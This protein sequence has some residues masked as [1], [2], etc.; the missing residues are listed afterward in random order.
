MKCSS[1]N[2]PAPSSLPAVGVVLAPTPVIGQ[3]DTSAHDYWR[4]G[5]DG[6]RD[7]TGRVW[8]GHEVTVRGY[9]NSLA[10]VAAV[11]GLAVE[12]LRPEELDVCDPRFPVMAGIACRKRAQAPSSDR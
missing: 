1:R 3:M 7:V 11:M 9:G 8:A 10:A 5:I 2:G 4:L 6:W 12:E